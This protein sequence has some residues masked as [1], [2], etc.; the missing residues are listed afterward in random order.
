LLGVIAAFTIP[1][2][3]NSQAASANNAKA[4]EVAAM[5]S[6]A[7]QA[8]QRGNIPTAN[9]SAYDLLPYMNY[10]GLVTPGTTIDS[11]VGYPSH[12]CTT[13][14][15][16]NPCYRLHNGGILVPSKYCFGEVSAMNAIQF[17]FDPD[18][19]DS[20]SLA[21]NPSKGVLFMLYYN[22]FI[23]SRSYMKPGTRQ[24]WIGGCAGNVQN[25]GDLPNADPS[26]F[27]W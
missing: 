15:G 6:E 14:A 10:V 16:N 24:S 27:S 2:I 3:L 21:D 8:Y 4:H 9:T 18:G 7:Y 19:L 13:V 5:V 20:N 17:H 1:K 23:T 11:I 22:G 26:W 25:H 12:T